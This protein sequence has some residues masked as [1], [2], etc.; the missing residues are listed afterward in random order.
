MMNRVVPREADSLILGSHL[1]GSD[2]DCL[3]VQGARGLLACFWV[4]FLGMCVCALDVLDNPWWLWG[5]PLSSA[6]G[7]VLHCN[8]SQV[9][10]GAN[11]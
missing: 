1:F 6:W 11:V 8:M 7:Q 3:D 4:V 2:P 5:L 9:I 10:G